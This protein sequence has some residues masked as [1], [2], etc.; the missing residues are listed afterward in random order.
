MLEELGVDRFESDEMRVAT[1]EVA[2]PETIVGGTTER[3]GKCGIVEL[4]H[5]GAEI[6]LVAPAKVQAGDTI[7]NDLAGGAGVGN[8]AGNAVGCGFEH[9]EAEGFVPQGG[10]DEGARLAQVCEACGV[11]D[12]A[13]DAGFGVGGCYVLLEG[14]GA[15]E[16]EREAFGRGGAGE[17][18]DTLLADEAAEIDEVLV[19]GG[20]GG[21]RLGAFYVGGQWVDGGAGREIGRHDVAG[22]LGVGDEVGEVAGGVAEVLLDG[23][24]ADT[25]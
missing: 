6:L 25:P 22:K 16:D 4:A 24:A 9:D 1:G 8:D 14:A 3:G 15:D 18:E 19:G 7:D 2:R 17:H 12:P 5:F 13:C 21:A 10:E 11:I 23:L 20:S